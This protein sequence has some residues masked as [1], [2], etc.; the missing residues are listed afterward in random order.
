MC[1]LMSRRDMGGT[2]GGKGYKHNAHIWNLK[3]YI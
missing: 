1:L 2:G 3:R